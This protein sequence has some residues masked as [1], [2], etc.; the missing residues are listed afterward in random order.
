MPKAGDDVVICI[1]REAI[2]AL[3]N[4]DS[5][6]KVGENEYLLKADSYD[7]PYRRIAVLEA[8]LRDVRTAIADKA[9][10]TLW[11]GLI[12]TAVDRIDGVLQN[13]LSE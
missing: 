2:E 10:D 5:P 9:P 3:G 11:I 13:P 4:G 7:Y 8:A 6:V 12:E 1:G